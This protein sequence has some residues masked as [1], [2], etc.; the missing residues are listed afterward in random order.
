MRRIGKRILCL[1]LCAVMCAVMLPAPAARATGD[2]WT[3]Y[4]DAVRGNVI[5]GYT[6]NAAAITVPDTIDGVHMN[7]IDR[8][9]FKNNT[10]LTS[11]TIPDSI[12]H[13]GDGAFSGCTKLQTVK[14]PASLDKLERMLF[15]DCVS[16]KSIE[17]PAGITVIE[18][19]VFDGCVSLKTLD[20]SG[21]SALES[22]ERCAFGECVG[23]Q[24]VTIPGCVKELGDSLFTDCGDDLV[25]YTD[26]TAG[27][28]A[29]YAKENGIAFRAGSSP[30]VP[31][32]TESPQSSV[33][34]PAGSTVSLSVKATGSG[35]NTAG[36]IA[37]SSPT[38]RRATGFRPTARPAHTA[39]SSKEIR[40]SMNTA[41]WYILPPPECIPGRPC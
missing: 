33:S 34:A 41:A 26:S 36:I 23:L 19:W 2:D 3:Y 21:C 4:T 30:S 1:L 10:T 13:I 7:A 24:S 15:S 27:L 32:I 38:V 29:D 12:Q 40:I 14:L 18:D 35:L 22:I 16:L 5:S 17:F 20:L 37:S 6:G 9:C 39:S 11:V 31:T 28:I 8:M 25:I